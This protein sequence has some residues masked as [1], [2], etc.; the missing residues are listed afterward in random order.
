MNDIRETS[1][2]TSASLL[3]T[4][5][6][7]GFVLCGFK[8]NSLHC[9]VHITSRIAPVLGSVILGVPKTPISASFNFLGSLCSSLLWTSRCTVVCRLHSC[10]AATKSFPI[11]P[12]RK[13]LAV[14]E[15]FSRSSC[16]T[17]LKVIP[18]FDCEIP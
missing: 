16:K 3:S 10:I 17:R 14:M 5:V 12:S 4:S 9:A 8:C 13:R 11:F 15:A 1:P 2:A 18:A 7:K 6:I